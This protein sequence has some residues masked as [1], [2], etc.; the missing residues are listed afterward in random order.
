MNVLFVIVAAIAIVLLITGG[1]VQSLNFLLWVGVVLFLI[2]LSVEACA[3][4]GVDPRTGHISA[5]LEGTQAGIQ[6]DTGLIGSPSA[7]IAATIQHSNA[8]DIS[9]LSGP[10]VTAGMSRG[11]YTGSVF[12]GVSC[13]APGGLVVGE[14]AGAGL[15]VPRV[16][17]HAG[18][19]DTAITKIFSGS[20]QD[21]Q[22]RF[23]TWML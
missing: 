23:L 4:V 17:V 19:T 3:V 13:G 6:G 9:Q 8:T 1:F 15:G 5:G 14:Q 10:F 20:F 18:I 11:L 2:G 21:S 22:K 16:E 7:G 12:V